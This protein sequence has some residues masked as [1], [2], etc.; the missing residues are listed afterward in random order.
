MRR[1]VLW[2]V[3]FCLVAALVFGGCGGDSGSSPSVTL[4]VDGVP[5]NMSTTSAGYLMSGMTYVTGSNILLESITIYFPGNS[6]GTW[7][8]SS[9]GATVIYRDAGGNIY[10]ASDSEGSYTITV[11]GYGPEGG[12]IEGTFSA[13]VVGS[14]T[15]DTHTLSGSFRVIWEGGVGGSG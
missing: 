11:T 10:V 4:D 15:G 12:F 13:T 5:V 1:N 14:G 9:G 8:S 3:G 7:E 2:A 6:T